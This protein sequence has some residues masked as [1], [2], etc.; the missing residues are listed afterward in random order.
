M[1]SYHEH[2]ILLVRLTSDSQARAKACFNKI[3]VKVD[4]LHK[5]LFLKGIDPLYNVWYMHGEA[6]PQ[7]VEPQLV[8]SLPEDNDDW[9]ED[10]LIEMENNVVDEFVSRPKILESLRN[11]SELALYEDMLIEENTLPNRTYKAKKVM[12]PMGIE[13]KKI[14]ACPND[15]ILY[16][17]AHRDLTEWPVC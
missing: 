7:D 8:E 4:D 15:C 3:K 17:N 12:C 10:N 6:E 9:D 1:V 5:H 2:L 14:H 11:D 13:Y 16:R